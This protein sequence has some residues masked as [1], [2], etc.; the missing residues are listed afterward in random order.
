MVSCSPTAPDTSTMASFATDPGTADSSLGSNALAADL[1]HQQA[2]QN[3]DQHGNSTSGDVDTDN[4]GSGKKKKGTKRRKVNHACLYCRRSHMTCDEGRPCQRWYE[5][6]PFRSP[7]TPALLPRLASRLPLL[8]LPLPLPR[9]PSPAVRLAPRPPCTVQHQARDRPP[10][11]RRAA[12]LHRKG[13]AAHARRRERHHQPAHRRREGAAWQ[14]VPVPPCSPQTP[15]TTSPRTRFALA[16][17][18][19]AVLR[20]QRASTVRRRYP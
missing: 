19:R 3:L 14:V 1:A 5:S 15:L 13:Q 10:L 16:L 8:P 2:A 12:S 17:A 20:L 18:L 4:D 7:F 9:T 11:P 6:F